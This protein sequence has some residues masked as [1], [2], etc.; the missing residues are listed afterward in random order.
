MCLMLLG[1]VSLK[2]MFLL[3]NDTIVAYRGH[4]IPNSCCCKKT[5]TT[6]WASACLPNDPHGHRECPHP[7]R[8]F[9]SLSRP[10]N[11]RSMPTPK[12]LP[13]H[14]RPACPAFTSTRLLSVHESC[15]SCLVSKPK[16][17][18]GVK[19]KAWAHHVIASTTLVRVIN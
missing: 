16:R 2:F 6:D 17:L 4:C 15:I 12:L 5:D 18:L 11:V 10:S 19:A 14:V 9:Y 7:L 1:H 8:T 13:R 3:S